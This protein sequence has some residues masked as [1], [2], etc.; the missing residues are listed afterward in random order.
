MTLAVQRRQRR[1]L[2][3][4]AGAEGGNHRRGQADDVVKR[5]EGFARG[6]GSSPRCVADNVACSGDASDRVGCRLLAMVGSQQLVVGLGGG[7]GP[8]GGCGL[9]RMPERCAWW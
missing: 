5:G 8:G 3:C 6:H 2:W 7:V 1:S 9:R 4:A